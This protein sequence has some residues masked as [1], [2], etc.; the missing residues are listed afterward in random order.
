MKHLLVIAVAA[1]AFATVG[2]QHHNLAPHSG[3]TSCAQTEQPAA[4]G[5]SGVQLANYNGGAI[6]DGAVHEHGAD[7]NCGEGG[8]YAGYG[9]GHEDL[10]GYGFAHLRNPQAVPVIPPQHNHHGGQQFYGPHGPSTAGV[11]YPYY[12]TR[13]PRDFLMANPPSIGY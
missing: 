2:C 5:N 12:T 7:C 4:P 10:S 3:C 9:G 6:S 11:A 8:G 1:C 13:G